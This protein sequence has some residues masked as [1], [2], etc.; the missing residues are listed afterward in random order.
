[1]DGRVNLYLSL[2]GSLT[3][4]PINTTLFDQVKAD[5]AEKYVN[6]P[7]STPEAQRGDIISVV[8]PDVNILYPGAAFRWSTSSANTLTATSTPFDP[9]FQFAGKSGGDQVEPTASTRYRFTAIGP[10]GT[11]I[12]DR[13]IM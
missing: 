1:M 3:D 12:E 13:N 7:G 6:T 9:T 5:I 11:D 8:Y 2:G 4:D 10:G